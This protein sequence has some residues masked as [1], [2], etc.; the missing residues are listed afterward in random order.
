MTN[1]PDN[2]AEAL[3]AAIDA[4]TDA[5]EVAAKA[6]AEKAYC[7]VAA[8]EDYEHEDLAEELAT[9]ISE[10]AKN[11]IMACFEAVDAAV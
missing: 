10:V 1:K 11:A 8:G 6:A 4:A 9:E 2:H 7:E 5:A 3:Q